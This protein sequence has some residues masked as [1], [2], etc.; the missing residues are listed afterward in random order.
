L[1]EGVV[2]FEGRLALLLSLPPDEQDPCAMQNFAGARIGEQVAAWMDDYTPADLT[3][4]G[5]P[6]VNLFRRPK[7]DYSIRRVPLAMHLGTFFEDGFDRRF[8]EGWRTDSG[9]REEI[10][11]EPMFDFSASMYDMHFARGAHDLGL[12]F[13]PDGK[14]L[15][16][17]DQRGFFSADVDADEDLYGI[18]VSLYDGH[19]VPLSS[20]SAREMTRKAYIEP[21]ATARNR[22]KAMAMKLKVAAAED[23]FLDE[24]LAPH[25]GSLIA[26][27]ERYLEQLHGLWMSDG[28]LSALAIDL[29]VSV[30]R[31]VA[32]AKADIRRSP[33]ALGLGRKGGWVYGRTEID[34]WEKSFRAE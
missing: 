17:H 15:H 20:L 25:G 18:E 22:A 7:N 5:Y 29:G 30:Q 28:D 26:A 9:I 27:R 32:E 31:I 16:P 23:R 13:K 12:L 11:G 24:V 19:E 1:D 21:H 4:H 8:P 3:K 33:L 2:T 14:T 10:R 6:E 34:S